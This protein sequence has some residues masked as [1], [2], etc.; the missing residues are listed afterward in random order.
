M[1]MDADEEVVSLADELRA[2]RG[3]PERFVDTMFDW[4][5]PELK[6]KSPE[7]WQRE[8]LRG[9]KEGLPLGKVRVACATGHGVGKTALTCWIILWAMSTRGDTR[10]I[11]TASNEAQLAT[12][13]RAELR[14]WMRLFRG[15]AFFDLT[16]TALIS[17][18]PA[19]EQTW[20]LDLLP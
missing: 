15:R 18:N 10:G 1:S 12:R 14:K 11:L 8:V 19:H 17:T 4:N 7:K 9:I 6:G 13:N 16:A 20:R 3:D 5:H 2:C